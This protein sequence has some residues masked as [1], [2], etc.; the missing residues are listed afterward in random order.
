MIEGTKERPKFFVRATGV[1]DR[2]YR[3]RFRKAYRV[4]VPEDIICDEE[5]QWERDNESA[6]S[7][8]R[9]SF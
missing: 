5:A 2:L 9:E 3:Q 8:L 4:V 7:D 6:N 1:Y